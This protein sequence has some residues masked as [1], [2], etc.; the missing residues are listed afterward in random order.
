MKPSNAL[1]TLIL[2]LSSIGIYEPGLNQNMKLGDATQIT[3]GTGNV[4]ASFAL[5]EK[6]GFKVIAR[7]TVPNP[8]L[9]ISD[10]SIMILLN[11][12]GMKYMGLTYFA[13]DMDQKVAA[14]ERFGIEFALKTDKEGKFFQGIFF[15]P[16]SLGVSLIN[17]DPS[18]IYQPKGLTMRNFPSEDIMKPE[19]LPNPKCGIFGEFSHPVK[20]LKISISYWEKLGFQSLS[21]NEEP[22]P[23]AILSDGLNILGLHQTDDFDHPAITYFAPDMGARIKKLKEEGL[24]SI[25]V[26]QGEGGNSNN[27]V[28][29]TPEG[30]KIF[31]FSF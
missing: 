9:Q 5:Y 3:I 10:G 27:V 26:F 16:D 17:Y 11:E 7:D 14:L 29:T 24:E 22:Y 30:Q 18:K 23:W 4:D 20:D 31:L 2:F 1:L 21:V 12:D 13:K 19:K 28:V 25:T 15:S 8:W 6:L